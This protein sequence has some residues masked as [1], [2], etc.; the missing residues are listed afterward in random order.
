MFRLEALGV[1]VDAAF[2][3]QRDLIAAL[4]CAT[5]KRQRIV[6]AETRDQCW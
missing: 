5:P 1:E 6:C 3:V 2:A 4:A